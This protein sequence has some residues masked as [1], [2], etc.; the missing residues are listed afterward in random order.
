MKSFAKCIIAVSVMAAG[1][2]IQAQCL[3][4]NLDTFAV[5]PLASQMTYGQGYTDP[6]VGLFIHAYNVENG[7]PIAGARAIYTVQEY[8]PHGS[9]HNHGNGVG[10]PHTEI[11]IPGGSQV[12]LPATR[13]LAATADSR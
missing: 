12:A 11:H 7:E 4:D 6:T 13:T 1:S 3:H 2:A 9:Q 8:Y 10:F 5:G